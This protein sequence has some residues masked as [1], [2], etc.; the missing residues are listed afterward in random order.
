MSCYHPVNV[1]VPLGTYRALS[2]MDVPCGSCLGC[3][4]DQARD[5]SVRIMHERECHDSAWFVTLTYD[6][7]HLPEFESLQKQHVQKF[8]KDLR[9]WYRYRLKKKGIKHGGRIRFYCC[10][11]YGTQTGRPHYHILLF[12][13]DFLDK[14]YWSMRDSHKVYRSDTLE[15]LWSWGNSE[16]GSVTFESAA[17]CARYIM[18]KFTN[19]DPDKV[20]EH[21]GY[22]D[23][24]FATMSR[25]PGIGK[26]WFDKYGQEV[27][28]HDSVI[29]RGKEVRPPKF[30]DALFEAVSPE[31]LAR[32]KSRRKSKVKRDEQRGQR[33]AARAANLK[34]RLSLYAGETL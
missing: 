7:K 12:G 20:L 18:K 14:T 17:Y 34:A 8:I 28:T 16:I 25:R 15:G 31:D 33:V 1:K 27:Y 5:W 6:D 30:Y 19:K 24:E 11:E 9:E 29:V 21:Y 22:K 26:E 2:P 32:L 23:P 4:A 10:G 13:F 3:R